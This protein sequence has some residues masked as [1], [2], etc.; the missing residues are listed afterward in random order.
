[1]ALQT[2]TWKLNMGPSINT[3]YRVNRTQFGD[4]YAQLSTIGINNKTQSWS[5]TKNG[6][7]QTVI[8]PIMDFIDAHAG[9]RPFLWTDPHGRTKQYT[10][11]GYSTSQNKGNHWQIT[12]KFEQFISV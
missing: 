7:L 3:Q 6:D 11:A 10:C 9:S 12:L 8:V 1:M 4:G 5:G 2:F